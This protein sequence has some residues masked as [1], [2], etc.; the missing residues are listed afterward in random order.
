M[1]IVIDIY[2]VIVKEIA[3]IL[4]ETDNTIIFQALCMISQLD[5]L[6]IST[7]V[8]LIIKTHKKS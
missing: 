6:S 7:M 4:S 5:V 1:N 8:D 3:K 2:Q